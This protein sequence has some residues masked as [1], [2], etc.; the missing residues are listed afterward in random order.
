MDGVVVESAH[1]SLCSGVPEA[2]ENREK[3]N[4]ANDKSTIQQSYSYAEGGAFDWWIH[5]GT[6]NL[7][8]ASSK[9]AEVVQDCPAL[10]YYLYLD[11]SS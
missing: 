8:I 2:I 5:D 6:T 1:Y 9:R 10:C 7:Q 3:E 4:L 11:S